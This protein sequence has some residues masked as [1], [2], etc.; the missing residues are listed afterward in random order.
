MGK[1]DVSPTFLV[2]IFRSLVLSSGYTHV[3]DTIILANRVSQLEQVLARLLE[4][5]GRREEFA[6]ILADPNA[7]GQDDAPGELDDVDLQKDGMND[8]G[9]GGFDDVDNLGND[10]FAPTSFRSQPP[11]ATSQTVRFGLQPLLEQE[12]LGRGS[13]DGS[14][15]YPPEL[16]PRMM[17]SNKESH[18][19]SY[20]KPPSV[21]EHEAALT[22]EVR[23]TRVLRVGS[24]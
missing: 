19:T 13:I 21:T 2:L 14:T 24:R 1:A 17:R 8:F 20:S 5:E 9:D 11:R 10:Q 15:S 18:E 16:D 12:G 22:L 3:N 6:D 7:T 23:H 4:R